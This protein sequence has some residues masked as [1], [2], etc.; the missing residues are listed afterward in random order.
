MQRVASEIGLELLSLAARRRRAVGS[1]D[2]GG[3][4][5]GTDEPAA[6]PMVARLQV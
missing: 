5:Q 2:A 3:E 6:S 4:G 1:A